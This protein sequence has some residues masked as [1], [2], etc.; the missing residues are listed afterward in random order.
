MQ[1]K[2]CSS[3]VLQADLLHHC[4]TCPFVQR[5]GFDYKF[6]CFACDYHTHVNHAMQFHIRTHT[7]EKP[8]KC[9]QCKY[10][11]KQPN[12]LKRHVRIR[13]HISEYVLCKHCKA[14]LLFSDLCG[15]CQTCIA[16]ERRNSDY[17]FVC[18][19][20]DYHTHFLQRM[21]RH[22]KTHTGEKPY[23]CN[24]CPYESAQLAHLKRHAKA[25]H[26]SIMIEQTEKDLR[27]ETN[28]Q[29]VNKLQ[30]QRFFKSRPHHIGP[31][32]NFPSSSKMTP[33]S[34]QGCDNRSDMHCV[35]CGRNGHM[36]RN[37]RFRYY[38][39]HVCGNQGH[40]K[41]MCKEGQNKR[42]HFVSEIDM[43]QEEEDDETLSYLL[44]IENQLNY[45]DKFQVSTLIEDCET[46]PET[47]RPTSK[48]RFV[49]FECTYHT[50]FRH[51]MQYHIRTHT[52]EK[53]FKC[54]NCKY[55]SKSSDHLKRHFKIVH[56]DVM[57]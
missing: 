48:Y 54:S 6:V 25:R 9:T 40:L 47:T 56:S 3:Y 1:C 53:P 18:Y 16:V 14:Y 52:G 19:G 15:H 20:C 33:S 55:E 30:E 42:Q 8:F 45:V 27:E 50:Q 35:C 38:K 34:S 41:N 22:I 12:D 43:R 4:K 44:S 11:C 5:S 17:K 23:K 7:G 51:S 39:C 29:D 49:C 24:Y 21:T 10:S 28:V 31:T 37:C 13:H 57:F 46:C 36:I 32:R 26:Y 2:N